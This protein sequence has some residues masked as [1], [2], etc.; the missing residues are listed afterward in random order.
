MSQISTIATLV[1]GT[2]D[3]DESQKNN[4]LCNDHKAEFSLTVF[5]AII[6]TYLYLL[7]SNIDIYLDKCTRVQSFLY[8]WKTDKPKKIFFLNIKNTV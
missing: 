7:H 6:Q 1:T 2:S 8:T 3:P 4:I 5:S